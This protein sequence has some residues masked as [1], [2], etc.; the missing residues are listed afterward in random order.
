M[1]ESK[2]MNTACTISILLFL[3][4]SLYSREIFCSGIF[5]SDSMY[6]HCRGNELCPIP[7]STFC[8]PAINNED[9]VDSIVAWYSDSSKVIKSGRG[10]HN[11]SLFYGSWSYSGAYGNSNMTYGPGAYT[12]TLLYAKS[13]T[14]WK[15]IA[16]IT[17]SSD[18]FRLTSEHLVHYLDSN[19]SPRV[20]QFPEQSVD[21]ILR[22]IQYLKYR[23]VIVI[24]PQ[25]YLNQILCKR[26]L[27]ELEWPAYAWLVIDLNEGTPVQQACMKMAIVFSH[28][29]TNAIASNIECSK[30]ETFSKNS[31]A[32]PK[33][34][35][36]YFI[37]Y[38]T[39]VIHLWMSNPVCISNYSA[40][41]GFSYF[42]LDKIPDDSIT[43][44]SSLAWFV[45]FS[46]LHCLSSSL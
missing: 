13:I 5:E 43:V 4:P 44:E 10:D 1:Y 2:Y 11:A 28:I 9:D 42:F 46:L 36:L 38:D 7:N 39:I 16:L 15:R 20:L 29:E 37:E 17:H 27:L 32:S 31:S 19:S 45:T 30:L 3:L 24:L 6:N 12:L 26:L 18:F 41:L 40:S 34:C 23:I 33:S 8:F 22:T 14:K 35:R 21:R 25:H